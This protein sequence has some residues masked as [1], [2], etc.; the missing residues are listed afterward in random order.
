MI[1]EII[2]NFRAC[3]HYVHIRSFIT[4]TFTELSPPPPPNQ[5]L[6][7]LNLMLALFTYSFHL[8]NC[9][10][11]FYTKFATVISLPLLTHT[12]VQLNPMACQRRF[13]FNFN[14]YPPQKYMTFIY[15][16]MIRGGDPSRDLIT[17]IHLFAC[18]YD[19]SQC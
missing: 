19:K 17:P 18:F 3:A 7:W 2:T 10:F 12:H 16:G 5:V 13:T 11:M 14:F 8:K 9:R 1:P 4:L 6:F 15:I